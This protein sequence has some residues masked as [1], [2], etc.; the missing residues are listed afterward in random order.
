MMG[1]LMGNWSESELQN[2]AL[3]RSTAT[4]LALSVVGPD[5][6]HDSM[7]KTCWMFVQGCPWAHDKRIIDD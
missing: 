6:F 3:L 7:E 5:F 1:L 2:A 4:Y